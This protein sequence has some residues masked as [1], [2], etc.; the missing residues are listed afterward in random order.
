[1][2]QSISPWLV[3]LIPILWFVLGWI[4]AVSVGGWDALFILI[5]VICSSVGM[6]F[7]TITWHITRRLKSAVL[8]FILSTISL[9]LV[10]V[11]IYGFLRP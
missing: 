9:F 5:I 6:L 8:V 3:H 7:G 4:I 11:L 1:M 10:I 2:R